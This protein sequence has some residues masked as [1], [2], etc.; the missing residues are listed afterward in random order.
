MR[1][2]ARWPAASQAATDSRARALD[3]GATA[4]SRSRMTS[5]APL[6]TALSKRSGRS[7]GTNSKL[8][9]I[10]APGD[11]IED[12]IARTRDAAEALQPLNRVFVLLCRQ[13]ATAV[14]QHDDFV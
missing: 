13:R 3:A 12:D 9:A 1:T 7:P 2:S 10:R 8:R 5:S 6:A 4:S 14:F 11:S